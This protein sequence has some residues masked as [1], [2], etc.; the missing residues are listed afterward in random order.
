MASV[1]GYITLAN[2][3]DFTGIDYSTVNSTA[4]TDT[5]VIFNI[6]TAEKAVN[7]YLGVS[8]GQTI[9]DGVTTATLILSSKLM[10]RQMKNLGYNIE[11]ND[12]YIDLSVAQILEMFLKGDIDVM[13]KSIPM[14]GANYHKPDFTHR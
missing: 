6:T 13:V 12:P 14:S 2:L 3:E 9:T 4:F 1:Y 5:R 8:T 11:G 7:A 10:N